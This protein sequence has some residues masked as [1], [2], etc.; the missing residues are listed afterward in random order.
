[1]FEL[2]PIGGRVAEDDVESALSEAASNDGRRWWVLHTKPR[3][4]KA[5]SEDLRERRIVHYLPIIEARPAY[6][7][8][9]ATVQLPLFQGYLF[10]FADSEDRI[11]SLKTKRVVSVLNVPDQSNLRREVSQIRRVIASREPFSLYPKLCRG[12]PCR[13]AVGALKGLVGV[14]IGTSSNRRFLVEVHALGQSICL[15]I[16]VACLEPISD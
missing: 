12:A 3:Q 11:E 6:R 2:S 16:D 9:R 8:R 7:S 13:V 1:M 5:L 15:E 10:L 14:V 4:E